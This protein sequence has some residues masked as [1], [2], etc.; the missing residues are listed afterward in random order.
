M[1]ILSVHVGVFVRILHQHQ[2][3]FREIERKV[4]QINA[5]IRISQPTRTL[6]SMS[7][8]HVQPLELEPAELI[9]TVL[10]RVSERAL[11]DLVFVTAERDGGRR[12]RVQ[13]PPR[14]HRR[15]EQ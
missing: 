14:L 2:Q 12:E 4:R 5:E 13:R 9:G 10:Q 1:D 15:V 11:P 8:L 3:V 6:L 7:L